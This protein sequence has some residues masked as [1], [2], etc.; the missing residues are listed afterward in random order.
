MPDVAIQ[1]TPTDL[2]GS[3]FLGRK[4]RQEKQC[5]QTR[6]GVVILKDCNLSV[7][8][9]CHLDGHGECQT[10]GAKPGIPMGLLLIETARISAGVTPTL[11]QV[12]AGA[13]MPTTCSAGGMGLQGWALKL[14]PYVRCHAHTTETT[15]PIQRQRKRNCGWSFCDLCTERVMNTR[16]APTGFVTAC[17]H[18]NNEGPGISGLGSHALAKAL[19][20]MEKVCTFEA[21]DCTSTVSF[22]S[23]QPMY[24]A[25]DTAAAKQYY[26]DGLVTITF[27]NASHKLIAYAYIE[28]D[29]VG[30]SSKSQRAHDVVAM[31]TGMDRVERE[32]D[33][34]S[35]TTRTTVKFMALRINMAVRTISF[36]EIA[37]VARMWVQS[38][39][40]KVCKEFFT[41][42]EQVPQNFVY[43]WRGDPHQSLLA[44]GMAAR[45]DDVPSAPEGCDNSWCNHTGGFLSMKRVTE[46]PAPK[47]VGK[48]NKI[49]IRKRVGDN[50]V[51][52]H[53]QPDPLE[54]WSPAGVRKISDMDWD[55][56]FNH[57][58]KG[59]EWKAIWN[60]VGRTPSFRR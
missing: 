55:E 40:W 60:Q 4:S 34:P 8:C 14:S 2:D 49:T 56:L 44:A 46:D 5:T 57:Y 33:V 24:N 17:G 20:L 18:C 42:I 10:V 15:I 45:I 38:Y 39:Y 23:G 32:H 26:S 48:G 43:Y 58:P 31:L 50:P 7:K 6:G 12:Y 37:Y 59:M 13:H 30:H 51:P 28:A 22:V 54:G 25:R 9:Q 41:G 36:A 47:G 27:E 53:T 29:G 11:A 21:S 52:S 1:V 35:C 3:V 19:Q 16:V